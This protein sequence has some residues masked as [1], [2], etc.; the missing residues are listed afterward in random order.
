MSADWLGNQQYYDT[1]DLTNNT[2]YS[3]LFFNLIITLCKR[4]NLSYTEFNGIFVFI[5]SLIILIVIRKYS[6]NS[7]IVLS[8]WYI[9]PFI[10]NIIQ[11]RA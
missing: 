1:V 10:D 8:L 7:N 9:F 5:A 3:N 2:N 4:F 11:K 6:N